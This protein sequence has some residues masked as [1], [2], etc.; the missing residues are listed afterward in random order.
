[1]GC[2]KAELIGRRVMLDPRMYPP[3]P[4]GMGWR[5][6]VVVGVDSSSHGWPIVELDREGGERAEKRKAIPFHLLLPLT[7]RNKL[8]LEEWEAQQ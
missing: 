5:T 7:E 1:M 8:L 3:K 2:R 4:Q 6:G